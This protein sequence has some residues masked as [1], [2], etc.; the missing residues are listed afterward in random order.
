MTSNFP[1]TAS[2]STSSGNSSEIFETP[3]SR[4]WGIIHRTEARRKID[5]ERLK[6]EQKENSARSNENDSATT[7]ENSRDG[8][9]DSAL[10]KT[11]AEQLLNTML[12]LPSRSHLHEENQRLMEENEKLKKQI[13][14]DQKKLEKYEKEENE[15][16]KVEEFKKCIAIHKLMVSNI[17]G[18]LLDV[19]NKIS[20]EE[21]RIK[22]NMTN[23]NN[24]G[25]QN[26]QENLQLM[27]KI[28]ND[29]E[30]DRQ[31]LKSMVI[32]LGE[33]SPKNSMNISRE[34]QNP[35]TVRPSPSPM[36][37]NRKFKPEE[38]FAETSTMNPGENSLETGCRN[39]HHPPQSSESSVTSRNSV[40]QH[41]LNVSRT[42]TPLSSRKP[43][44]NSNPEQRLPGF[45]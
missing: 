7:V 43:S 3:K 33:T 28:K 38:F 10:V 5:R 29:I 22:R 6:E 30:S 34:E 24:S 16:K 40:P 23:G 41:P 11:V 4:Y 19:R 9:I 26:V 35:E 25:Q 37:N 18:E 20:D 21:A 45:V 32:A 1:S 8:K 15:Q 36:R 14:L 2:A 42:R 13:A 27:K 17:D 31:K 39:N 12:D 44:A